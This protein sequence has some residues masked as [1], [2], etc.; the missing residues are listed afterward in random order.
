[1]IIIYLMKW[2]HYGLHNPAHINNDLINDY[3][4]YLPPSLPPPSPLLYY[5]EYESFSPPPAH[6]FPLFLATPPPPQ[7]DRWGG[8]I[9][10][11]FINNSQ[12]QIL[13]NY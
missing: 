4:Y 2:T 13:L 5:I 8:A 12:I 1:M 11:D 6:Y 3:F 9:L 10:L 7:G